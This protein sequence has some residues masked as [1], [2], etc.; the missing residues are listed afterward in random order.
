[1][2]VN[3]SLPALS[4]VDGC[5]TASEIQQ[6]HALT[7]KTGVFRKEPFRISAKIIR[8]CCSSTFRPSTDDLEYAVSLFNRFVRGTDY[9]SFFY[10]TLIRTHT[11]NHLYEE[12][13]LLFYDMLCC[14][15]PFLP[16][17]FTFPSVL[18]SCAHLSAIE[19]GKQIHCMILKTATALGNQFVQNSLIHMYA[20]CG[21]IDLAHKAFD[22][23]PHRNVVSWNM[24]IDVFA[25]CGHIDSSRQFFDNMPERNVVSWNSVIAGYVRNSLPDEALR[26]FLQ[27]LFLG[28]NPDESTLVSVVSAIADLG[29]LDLGKR[30]HGYLTRHQFSLS[31]VL[32]TA[33]IDMYSNCGSIQTAYKIFESFPNKTV[34]HWTSMI[35]GFANHGMARSSL[36][37]FSQMQRSG[38]EPNYITFIGVLTACNHGGLVVEG[39]KHFNLMRRVYNI[40]PGIEHYGCLIDLLGRMGH[41]EEAKMI[42]ER[43][44]ME[45]G[46]VIWASVLAACRTHG[47][48]KTAELAAQKLIELEPG[49]AGCYL[50][51]S[52]IY[53][54]M[55]R[56]EDLGR[57]RKLM[58]ERGVEKNPGL[59]WIEVDVELHQFAVGDKF[60]PR[61]GEIYRTLNMLEC[62]LKDHS[63]RDAAEM[64]YSS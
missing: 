18:K 33:L 51:M 42:V 62:H 40:N 9:A 56:W 6:I 7:I 13:F 43:M 64:V 11:Q 32:G 26:L 63:N 50:L 46:V 19:E 49:Y 35:V 21:E 44:P 37:I 31:G 30:I 48:T 38:T 1:M 16:D 3:L 47:N 41:I 15:P 12:A 20:R 36:Q 2:S 29:L 55:G 4:L 24:M 53:A 28:L 25:K 60:H 27:F 10:N 8:S 14:S 34:G 59:S 52:D 61:C 58:E 57:I 54:K 45:P 23:M 39:L 17:N 22:S 5:S